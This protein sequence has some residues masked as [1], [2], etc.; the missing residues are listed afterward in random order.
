MSSF[1]SKKQQLGRGAGHRPQFSLRML[2]L[3]ITALGLWLGHYV[4][5]VHRLER[6][7][8]DDSEHVR[9]VAIDDLA[10]MGPEARSAHPSLA[11]ALHDPSGRVRS[12]AVWALSRTGED[13]HMLAPLLNDDELRLPAAEA[14]LWCG[15]DPAV[16]MRAIIDIKASEASDA[17]YSLREEAE[18]ITAFGPT[19]SAAAMPVVLESLAAE[20]TAVQKTAAG[21]LPLLPRPAAGVLPALRRFLRH[22][23]PDI[24]LA[25][26][27]QLLRLG[28]EARPAA[29]DLDERLFD[30]DPLVEQAAAAARCA[31]GNGGG[32]LPEALRAGLAS[33][34]PDRRRRVVRYLEALGPLASSASELLVELL[35]DDY[36]DL[37]DAAEDALAAIGI[38][39]VE[40]LCAAIEHS[41][42]PGVRRRAAN[43]LAKFGPRARGAAPILAGA[44]AD[45]SE[46]VRLAAAAALAAV[47]ERTAPAVLELAALIKSENETV[48][49]SAASAVEKIGNIDGPTRE[50][51]R[52]MMRSSAAPVRLAA[53]TAL[54]HCGERNGDVL[55][56]LISLAEEENR[57]AVDALKVIG[58]MGQSAAPAGDRLIQLLGSEAVVGAGFGGCPICLAVSDSLAEVGPSVVPRLLESL[59]NPNPQVRGLAARALGQMGPPARTAVPLLVQSLGDDGECDMV[60]GC[61]GGSLVVRDEAID[62][63]GRIGPDARAATH[64]LASM[65]VL[66]GDDPFMNSNAHIVQAF[67][68]IGPNARSALPTILE[69][70]SL[71]QPELELPITEALVRIAPDH[72]MTLYKL[73]KAWRTIEQQ[74][75]GS[76]SMDSAPIAEAIWRLGPRAAPLV[77]DL[78]RMVFTAP[79]LAVLTRCHAAYALAAFEPQRPAAVA[80]LR[81]IAAG[82]EYVS[83]SIASELLKELEGRCS[84]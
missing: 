27:E 2:F 29:A 61:I 55:Q 66:A 56:V 72:P 53:A 23:R 70:T 40:N 42:N 3:A 38:P 82:R 22:E 16:V 67:G 74:P 49:R 48:S 81:E 52:E 43:V 54:V 28:Q 30:T 44:L 58:Q 26:A 11:A 34:D 62:A 37:R 33:G 65:L 20:N 13:W 75:V 7:L 6:R 18:L 83:S 64:R 39:S 9:L 36:K 25:A 69:L 63:L 41:R 60:F 21:I 84:W 31:I 50:Q 59:Q 17:A 4:D 76:Y 51:L 15:G 24:R 78:H 32:E 8:H 47:G 71:K 14:I 73:Q 57:S 68:G 35:G 10:S 19:A 12:A 77:R 46:H 5:P 1:I 45:P 79:L 80:Y